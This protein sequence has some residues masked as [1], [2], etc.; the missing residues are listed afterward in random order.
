MTSVLK[1]NI[2]WDKDEINTPREFSGGR[3]NGED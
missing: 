2:P 3:D 1:A